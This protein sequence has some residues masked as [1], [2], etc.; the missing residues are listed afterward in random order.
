MTCAAIHLVWIH[1]QLLIVPCLDRCKSSSK[2]LQNEIHPYK[3]PQNPIG[4][5]VSAL[6]PP[7]FPWLQAAKLANRQLQTRSP[8]FSSLFCILRLAT[9]FLPSISHPKTTESPGFAPLSQSPAPHSSHSTANPY[10]SPPH[11][12][13]PP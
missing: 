3:H 7:S 9:R 5:A 2:E 13:T 8:S 10:E 1:F 12:R 11:A 4:E 6:L